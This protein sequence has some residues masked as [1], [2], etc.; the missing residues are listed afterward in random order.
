[1]MDDGTDTLTQ[2]EG[3]STLAKMMHGTSI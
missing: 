2:G 1:M 3:G